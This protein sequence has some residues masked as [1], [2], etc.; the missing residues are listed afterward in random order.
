M[1]IAW[2]FEPID[3][4]DIERWLRTEAKEQLSE[5]KLVCARCAAHITSESAQISIH[6]GHQHVFTN[7]HGLRFQIGCFGAATGCEFTGTYTLEWTWFPDY[8]W[9]VTQCERCHTHLGWHFRD[10]SGDAK[11]PDFFGFISDRLASEN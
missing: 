10:T 4:E 7:P 6:G 5:P 3:D 1:A 11:P 9:R 2:A 8:A